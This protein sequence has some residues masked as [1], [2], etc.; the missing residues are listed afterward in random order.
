MST[1]ACAGRFQ[2][3]KLMR[4]V[5][6]KGSGT[7]LPGTAPAVVR[8][9]T[10]LGAA[11]P[12]GR[13]TNSVF[14]HG[15]GPHRVKKPPLYLV[16]GPL[17]AGKTT[18]LT[19]LLS[20]PRFA[21]ARVI[22]NEFASVS[23]DTETLHRHAA[24]VQTI[25]GI[26][27]CCSTGDELASA[28][29]T[30]AGSAEPVFIEATGV[31]NSLTLVERLVVDDLLD[32]YDLAHALF[33]IDAAEVARDPG[34]IE[35][36]RGELAAADTVVVSKTD[37]LDART[38]E[39]VTEALRGIGVVHIETT[40]EGVIDETVLDRPSR[41]LAALATASGSPAVTEPATS[42]YSIVDL[43]S[44]LVGAEQVPGLWEAL[45]AVGRLRRMKGDLRDSAGTNWHVEA[46]PS[47][48]RVTPG[49]ATHPR[50][51]LIGDRAREVTLATVSAAIG[52]AVIGAAR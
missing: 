9:V 40:C 35:T 38:A 52:A 50:L 29:S 2:S 30:L 26:C 7:A 49:E 21:S 42:N 1:P 24:A 22:E 41:M 45:R 11:R 48:C 25:A 46:T 17:G 31:A 44:V 39:T 16:N 37:L 14:V 12:G 34:L 51:V 5:F 47:Q 28:L 15:K 18:V 19:H 4:T 43:E 10:A 36:H 20:R 6:S 27:V 8:R 23:V 33:V 13:V 32:R 3:D